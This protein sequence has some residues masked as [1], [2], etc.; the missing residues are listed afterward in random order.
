MALGAVPAATAENNRESAPIYRESLLK[1]MRAHDN[2]G[3]WEKKDDEEILQVFILTKEA[4]RKIPIIGEVNSKTLWRIDVFYT[5][6]CY[7]IS[8][9]TELDATP[10]LKISDEGFGR[11]VI[12]VGRLV[13]LS[14]TLRDVHRF[15]FESIE[16]LEAAGESTLHLC[17]DVIERF[18]AV[19]RETP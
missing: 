7:A 4:R 9:R 16:A 18:A 13:V 3:V 19:A 6:L 5:A 11:A 12:C 17:L 14:R 15:G 1:L 8:R 2:Y 10:I